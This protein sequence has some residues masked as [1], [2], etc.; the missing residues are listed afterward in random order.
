MVRIFTGIIAM[1]GKRIMSEYRKK[2][3]RTEEAPQNSGPYLQGL[4]VGPFI[5]T[6]GEGPLVPVTGE[7]VDGTI[8]AD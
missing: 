6:S 8:E 2:E 3:I 1:K 7:I 5:F 4:A